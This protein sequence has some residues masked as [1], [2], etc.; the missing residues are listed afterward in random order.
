VTSVKIERQTVG[1][2]RLGF[3]VPRPGE[4]IHCPPLDLPERNSSLL[5]APIHYTFR[6]QIAN[7][8]GDWPRFHEADILIG[9]II[10]SFSVTSPWRFTHL[11]CLAVGLVAFLRWARGGPNW[12]KFRHMR[13]LS[14][15]FFFVFVLLTQTLSIEHEYERTHAFTS[16]ALRETT[17]IERSGQEDAGRGRVDYRTCVYARAPRHR[18]R[19]LTYLCLVNI[20]SL[21][22]YFSHPSYVHRQKS[23]NRQ[24]GANSPE[25]SN[26]QCEHVLGSDVAHYTR[27]R[28]KKTRKTVIELPCAVNG[29]NWSLDALATQRPGTRDV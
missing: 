25:S 8:R 16:E 19:A 26:T 27:V 22:F 24:K 23:C 10:T 9:E 1:D 17:D 6:L 11:S 7:S 12:I 18:L 15:I 5:A 29:S 14:P 13:V 20:A 28:Q 4:V 3:A 2:S 21:F